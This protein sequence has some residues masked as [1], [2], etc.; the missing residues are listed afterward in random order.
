MGLFNKTEEEL[1]IEKEKKQLKELKEAL[2]D[3]KELAS[4]STGLNKLLEYV[5]KAIDGKEEFFK[6][7][8]FL[9][10]CFLKYTYVMDLYKNIYAIKQLLPYGKNTPNYEFIKEI[11]ISDFVGKEGYLKKEIFDYSMYSLFKNFD[12]YTRVMRTLK[13][14]NK[15]IEN[16]NKLN[17]YIKKSAKFSIDEDS[18]VKSIISTIEGL[19]DSVLNIDTYLESEIEK[20]KKRVGIYALS[21]DDIMTASNTM[22]RI[23]SQIDKIDNYINTIEIKGKDIINKANESK[24]QIKEAKE[25]SIKELKD[26]RSTLE[27]ELKHLLE[28]HLENVKIEIN[29]KADTVFSEILKKY[30]EQLE[31]FRKVS[32]NLSMQSARE[33]TVLKSETD[34][35]LNELR[36]YVRN[37]PELKSALNTAEESAEVRDRILQLIEK[38]KVQ[39]VGPEVIESKRVKGIS[40]VVV[41]DSP[42][43]TIP[44]EV[45]SKNIQIIKP[46]SFKNSKQFANRMKNIEAELELR[47]AN[48]EIFHDKIPEIIACLMVGDWPYLFGP[49]GAGKGYMVEQVGSLLGQKVIDSG[50]ITEPYSI[51]G[52][53]DPQGQFRATPTFEGITEGDLIFFDEFDNGNP[54]TKVAL[55]TMYSNL[56]D[57]INHPELD[58]YIK[59]AGE[60]DVP[61][62]PNTRMIAA[63]NTDGT[64]SD[65]NFS[66]RPKTDES[67]M[68]RY[69]PIYIPYDN[70]VEQSILKDHP[71]WYNFFVKFREYCE[72]YASKQG[73][74]NAQGNAST[75]D[76][77]DILRDV[78]LNAKTMDQMMNQYFV[79][80]KEDD[81]REALLRRFAAAYEIDLD[82]EY[83]DYKGT[84]AKASEEEIAKQFVKRARKGIRG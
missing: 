83:D 79:Q 36:E 11:I 26:Y 70:R 2:K 18:F 42:R 32:Q 28:Q 81:Y 78:T 3:N 17:E 7:N 47:K 61:I 12:N 68:E 37:N 20:D 57:K 8:D 4:D 48:G 1:R 60:I 51:Y 69:K 50:K 65:E 35:S 25:L 6:D 38:E 49:S 27:K 19:D 43:V 74:D 5:D 54:D 53:I 14:N 10:R 34:K 33:L 75:R 73:E 76:A 15:A 55:N 63:G 41:T 59:F 62:N 45:A 66:E 72:E 46:Y 80:I 64:G 56:R 82:E 31:E 40:R 30:Q 22:R 9:I 21:H 67:I 52:Y 77:S 84:L 24:L 71:N 23:D 39:E 44:D 58:K 16:F 13:N 29:N